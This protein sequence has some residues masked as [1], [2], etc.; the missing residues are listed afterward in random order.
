MHLLHH[1]EID[2]DKVSLC[3]LGFGCLSLHT[4]GHQMLEEGCCTAVFWTA[5]PS[6]RSHC[7]DSMVAKP[8]S[9]QPLY[10]YEHIV[11]LQVK[12]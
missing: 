8:P 3:T 6:H 7:M 12:L 11:R 5:C 1:L 9:Y 2:L 10:K 4:V